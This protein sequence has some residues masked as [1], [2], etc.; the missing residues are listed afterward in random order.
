MIDERTFILAGNAVFTLTR[1]D[2]THYTYR[3]YK[4]R[5]YKS[6]TRETWFVSLG[7]NYHDSISLGRLKRAVLT[8]HPVYGNSNSRMTGSASEA[9]FLCFWDALD[10]LTG[11]GATQIRLQHA[12]RCCC[13][14]REL[15][16][17]ESIDLG[18]GP[19][20]RE[21]VGL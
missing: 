18:I 14:G 2:G 9:T 12:G 5:P 17:P 10:S 21:K 20:C 6:F 16:N 4:A 7:T 8:E 15:T 3:V 11:V 13:C 1:P 19:E